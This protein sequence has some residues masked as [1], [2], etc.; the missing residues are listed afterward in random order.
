MMASLINGPTTI[1]KAMIAVTIKVLLLEL[2][3]TRLINKADQN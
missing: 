1:T 2:D 3:I